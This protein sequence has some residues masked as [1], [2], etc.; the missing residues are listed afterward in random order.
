MDVLGAEERDIDTGKEMG[1][2][3]SSETQT[4]EKRWNGTPQVLPWPPWVHIGM[5]T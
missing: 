5:H 3:S 2:D 1:Q 4:Q